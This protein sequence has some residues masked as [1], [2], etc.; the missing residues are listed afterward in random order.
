LT[1]ENEERI[2]KT[3]EKGALFI[4]DL[5]KLRQRLERKEA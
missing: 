1:E 3:T 4:K 2:W 5:R